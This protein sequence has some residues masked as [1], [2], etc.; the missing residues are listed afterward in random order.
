MQYKNLEKYYYVSRQ[1]YEDKYSQYFNDMSAKK[2]DFEI[3][4]YRAFYVNTEEVTTLIYDIM[5]ANRKL[6]G[7]CNDLPGIAVSRYKRNKLID[8]INITNEIEGVHSTKREISDI[9]DNV[10]GKNSSVRLFNLV[11][12]YERIMEDDEIDLSSCEAIRKLYDEIVLPEVAAE[13]P[14][15]EPDGKYFRKNTVSVWNNKQEQIHVGVMPE[16]AIDDAM[17]KALAIL[18]G[19][20]GNKLVDIAVFHYLLG[21]IHPFYDGNGRMNRFI[22]SYML[23]KELNNLISYGLSAVIKENKSKYNKLFSLTNNKIN[24]GDLT[25]FILNFLEF[26]KSSLGYMSDKLEEKGKK[27]DYYESVLQRV[28]RGKPKYF[29]VIFYM[30]QN[31]LFGFEGFKMADLKDLLHFSYPVIKNVLKENES[32]VVTK[33]IGKRDVFVMNLQALDAFASDSL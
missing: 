24:R 23:S 19:D 4:G 9:L 12:K 18:N 1:E 5:Q 31:T 11:K 17:N 32:I 15:N 14:D 25:P 22:S 28:Y 29:N 6:D 16:E 26:I 20:N 3:N 13:C 2:Y 30:L 7:I 10:S 8:E 21:Y 33:Q 27:L